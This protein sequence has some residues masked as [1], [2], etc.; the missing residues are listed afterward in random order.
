M[1]APKG[2]VYQSAEWTEDML[3]A[4]TKAAYPGC[5]RHDDRDH[6]LPQG[7]P[8]LQEQRQHW[9]KDELNGGVNDWRWDDEQYSNYEGHEL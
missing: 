6:E 5:K 8:S 4:L 1:E 3:E 7:W 2:K 9:D